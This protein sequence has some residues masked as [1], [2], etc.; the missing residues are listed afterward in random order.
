MPISNQTQLYSNPAPMSGFEGALQGLGAYL[1]GAAQKK[2]TGEDQRNKLLM[3]LIPT[4]ASRGQLGSKETSMDVAGIPMT[5]GGTP[6]VTALEESQRRK[7]EF[8]AD[9]M[10]Q[11]RLIAIKQM[12]SDRFDPV[13]QAQAAVMK[14]YAKDK[15]GK[16]DSGQMDS[17]A[18]MD[19]II[20]GLFSNSGGSLDTEDPLEAEAV[21]WLQD[22]NNQNDPNYSS[23]AQAL[24]MKRKNKTALA[25]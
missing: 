18:L 10:T 22:P 24:F 17:N 4:L 3:S 6:Q 5:F 13:K 2:I 23:V 12:V 25:L 15:G 21:A 9:F 19:S 7:N 16:A 8:E 1:S 14:N 20:N 11:A